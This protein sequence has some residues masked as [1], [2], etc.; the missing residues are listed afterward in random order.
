[1]LKPDSTKTRQ[2]ADVGPMLF[3]RD[4]AGGGREGLVLVSQACANPACECRDVVL[5]GWVVDDK[6]AGVSLEN[7]VI[8]FVCNPGGSCER[9]VLRAAVDLERGTAKAIVRPALTKPWALEWLRHELDAELLATLER[10]F[11]AAKRAPAPLHDWRSD[12]WSHWKPGRDAR[13]I[14]VEPEDNDA[15]E[16]SFDGKT[17]VVGDHYC[18]EPDCK[19]E[20]VRITFWLERGS[21]RAL[22]NVG[23]VCVNPTMPAGAQLRA[24]GSALQLLE[25]LWAA[26]CDEH[27][28]TSLLVHRRARMRELAPEIHR[29]FGDARATA[30]RPE[31]VGRNDRQCRED[32]PA[33]DAAVLPTKTGRNDRCPCGSGKKYKRCCAAIST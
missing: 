31:T 18:V 15:G 33:R 28:V 2:L 9:A 24:H 10:H 13:W 4:R 29:L 19:C 16:L 25:R 21:D 30:A 6:L 23:D 26:W 7:G 8:R 22:G 3:W 1:M 5:E 27:P 20:E 17:Y 14:D 11:H 32:R 12:D